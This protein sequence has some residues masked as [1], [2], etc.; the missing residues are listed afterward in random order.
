LR[1]WRKFFSLSCWINFDLKAE[2]K[3]L[4]YAFH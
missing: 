2:P 1:A 3:V 4:I